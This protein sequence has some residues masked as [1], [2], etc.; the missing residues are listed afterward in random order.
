M[1]NVTPTSSSKKK[2]K[3][4]SLEVT[5]E[6]DS[7]VRQET[8]S[9][10][11]PAGESNL[12]NKNPYFDVLYKRVKKLR[13]LMIRIEKYESIKNSPDGI[14][15]NAD[16][17]NL[18]ERKGETSGAIKEFDEALKQVESVEKEELKKQVEQKKAQQSERDQAIANAVEEAKA[19]DSLHSKLTSLTDEAKNEE[20][21]EGKIREVL[22]LVNKLQLGDESLIT[23]SLLNGVHESEEPATNNENSTHGLTYSQLLSLIKNPPILESPEE[24]Q[25]EQ[26]EIQETFEEVPDPQSTLQSEHNDDSTNVTIPAGGLQFMYHPDDQSQPLENTINNTT[27]TYQST[28]AEQIP[29]VTSTGDA[30]ADVQYQQNYDTSMVEQPYIGEHQQQFVAEQNDQQVSLEH[31]ESPQQEEPP[32][33]AQEQQTVSEDLAD[34]KQQPQSIQQDN[35]QPP[36]LSQ[37]SSGFR[38]RA[39]RNNRGFRG[40]RRDSGGYRDSNYRDGN[41]RDGRDGGGYRENYRDGGYREGGYREVYRDGGNFRARGGPGPRGG[42]RGAYTGNRGGQFRQRS[43]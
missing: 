17:I 3:R 32:V 20:L 33:Y 16:Q 14:N 11:T 8:L 1:P 19:V 30:M 37:G 27:Y 31:E 15:L 9:P 4:K 18:L 41:Y 22:D 28:D 43:Q 39:S 40:G 36:P 35:D 34:S 2:D 12:E 23:K 42:G 10:I 29:V 13:K 26:E 5:T 6:K 21:Y 38:G 7:L 24:P 25:I